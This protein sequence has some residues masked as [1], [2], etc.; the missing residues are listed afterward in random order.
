MAEADRGLTEGWSEP[1]RSWEHGSILESLLIDLSRPSGVWTEQECE[2]HYSQL[3]GHQ[4]YPTIVCTYQVC[5]YPARTTANTPRAHTSAQENH[6]NKAEHT[7]TYEL[8][9]TLSDVPCQFD[10]YY[11]VQNWIL[12]SVCCQDRGPSCGPIFSSSAP[13]LRIPRL[14]SQ[15]QRPPRWNTTQL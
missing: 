5:E 8:G 13:S 12:F 2:S 10:F 14:S 6:V 7:P 11:K 9:G 1:R 4:T 15:H 3:A